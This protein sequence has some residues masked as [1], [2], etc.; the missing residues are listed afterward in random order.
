MIT[1]PCEVHVFNVGAFKVPDWVDN[2]FPLLS[3]Y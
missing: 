1:P 2:T 3:R